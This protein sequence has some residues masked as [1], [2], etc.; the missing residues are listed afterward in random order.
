VAKTLL[1]FVQAMGNNSK[2]CP[3]LRSMSLKKLILRHKE[4]ILNVLIILLIA[5][6]LLFIVF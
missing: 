6:V 4:N 2:N 1:F 5:S 3:W